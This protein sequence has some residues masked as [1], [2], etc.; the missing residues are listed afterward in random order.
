MTLYGLRHAPTLMIHA[1]ESVKTVQ[2]QLGHSD[3]GITLRVYAQAVAKSQAAAR[4]ALETFCAL[5][6]DEGSPHGESA[7]VPML[8][9]VC[10]SALESP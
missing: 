7:A 9:Q 6:P 10:D 8:H 2:A 3:S 5:P 1:G 4:R